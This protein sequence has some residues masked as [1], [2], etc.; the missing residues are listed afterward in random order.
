MKILVMHGVN[1]DL[2]GKRE[3]EHYGTQTLATIN[4]KLEALAPQLA[5]AAGIKGAVELVFFQTNVEAEFLAKL[6][7]GFDGA[8]L[9]P[10]AW[11]HT[12]IALAD[13]L[14]ALGL[15]FAEAHLSN[16]A[17][18][19]EFRQ[20]SYAAPHARGVV[21]G[22]GFGSYAAALFGLLLSLKA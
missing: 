4:K 9:N 20:K 13:R 1:L 6:G 19:E 5:R 3:A 11:T 14:K 8:V 12:S 22:F 2:L 18:R 15:P 21:F 17:A 7:E 10:A 16:I